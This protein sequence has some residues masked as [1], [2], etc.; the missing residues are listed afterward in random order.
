M[1][2]PLS[3]SRADPRFANVIRR[4]HQALGMIDWEDSGMRDAA[5]DIA[6]LLSHPN[7]EDLLSWEAWQAFLEPY[8]AEQRRL[9]AEIEKRLHYYNAAFP[10]FWLS[11]LMSLGLRLWETGRL[12]GWVINEMNPNERLRRYLARVI[13]WP[14]MEYELHLEAVGDYEFFDLG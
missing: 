14:S 10:L 6:D 12:E 4:P 7:Q 2:M 13:A 8:L 5:R 3:F 1:K 11:G 9:D